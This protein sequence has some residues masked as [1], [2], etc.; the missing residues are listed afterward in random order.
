MKKGII[1]SSIVVLSLLTAGLAYAHWIELITVDG[2]IQTGYLEVEFVDAFSNDEGVDPGLKD[3]VWTE[4]VSDTYSDVYSGSGV[5]GF[6]SKDI[7]S[8]GVKYSADRVSIAFDNVYPCY[9][10]CTTIYFSNTGTI[11]AH[12]EGF[13]FEYN[14]DPFYG[15]PTKDLDATGG[16]E[17]IGWELTLENEHVY[18]VTKGDYENLPFTP[19]EEAVGIWCTPKLIAYLMGVDDY[20]DP[21][22]GYKGV[23]I[24]SGETYDLHLY[25]HFQE[26]TPEGEQYT[27][28]M[29]FIWINW[30][31]DA[32]NPL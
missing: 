26:H 17:L 6:H 28:D 8:T 32:A 15:D 29:S 27:F 19:E 11:P 14:G 5:W 22:W 23:Q 30:N 31:E 2:F 7:A 4:Y 16:L 20:G 18:G 25:W 1:L 10:P 13:T 3:V 24:H 9:A 21:S 12:M